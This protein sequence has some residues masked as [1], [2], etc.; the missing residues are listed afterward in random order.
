MPFTSINEGFDFFLSQRVKEQGPEE[1]RESFQGIIIKTYPQLKCCTTNSNG[2][3]TV[4]NPNLD[5]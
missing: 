1:I 3:K 4:F 5:I 2:T